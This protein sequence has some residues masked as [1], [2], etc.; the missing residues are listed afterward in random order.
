MRLIL[1]RGLG[2]SEDGNIHL[3]QN[4][5]RDYSQSHPVRN[6]SSLF[7]KT[8]HFMQKLQSQVV[9]NRNCLKNDAIHSV[10]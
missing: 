7:S 2:S 1:P 4:C 8:E 5:H 6:N 9:Q 3:Y 10:E